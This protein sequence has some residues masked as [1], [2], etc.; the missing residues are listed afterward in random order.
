MHVKADSVIVQSD[1]Y[2]LN[3]KTTVIFGC[4]FFSPPPMSN[5]K[6]VYTPTYILRTLFFW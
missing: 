6:H 5:A 4:W 2:T 3:K 1:Y